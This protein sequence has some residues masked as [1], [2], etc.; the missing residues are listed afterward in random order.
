MS[1]FGRT[2]LEPHELSIIAWEPDR[3]P[4]FLFSP[5]AHLCAV[6][7][8]T[9]I[10]LSVT[11]NKQYTHSLS[12]VYLIMFLRIIKCYSYKNTHLLLFLVMSRKYINE[13]VSIHSSS[14]NVN[15]LYEQYSVRFISYV[16]WSALIS[17]LM[18]KSLVRFLP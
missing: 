11:L 5:H 2:Q 1:V 17:L 13:D 10:S 18:H 7:C 6:T 4:Y 8:T 12:P 15:C 3:W 14:F 16:S 9:E